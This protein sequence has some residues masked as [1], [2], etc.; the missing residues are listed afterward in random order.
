MNGYSKILKNRL[1]CFYLPVTVQS[2]QSK[3]IKSFPHVH[4]LVFLI[5]WY[6]T[7]D[8]FCTDLII[9]CYFFLS[10]S[11]LEWVVM[12]SLCFILF[13]SISSFFDSIANICT[14][15]LPL[16]NFATVRNKS[17]T[18]KK[19]LNIRHKVKLVNALVGC[20]WIDHDKWLY[21]GDQFSNF[22]I[23]L[24]DCDTTL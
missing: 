9:N 15:L 1:A 23:A 3:P 19:G 14:S 6:T 22:S 8:K 5:L 12:V 18:L 2:P 7:K 4:S 16:M 20:S 24:F 17:A 10:A 13:K 11:N 21:R